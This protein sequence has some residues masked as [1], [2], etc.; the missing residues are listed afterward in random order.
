MGIRQREQANL[1]GEL[2]LGTLLK[3]EASRIIP[4][5]KSRKAKFFD[6]NTRKF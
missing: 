5:Q 3:N 4:L 2:I 1:F 6:P